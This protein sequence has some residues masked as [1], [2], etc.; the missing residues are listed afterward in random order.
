MLNE[1]PEAKAS[2]LIATV[3]ASQRNLDFGELIADLIKIW[4][5]SIPNK[6]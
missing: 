3:E 5:E 1:T 4:I 2:A 6:K